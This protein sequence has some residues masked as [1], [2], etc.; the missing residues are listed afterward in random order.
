MPLL[1]KNANILTMDAHTPRADAAIIVGEYFAYMGDEN[2]ARAFLRSTGITDVDEYDCGGNFVMPGFNDSHMHFLNYVQGKAAVDLT[3]T[4]SVEDVVARMK[5]AIAQQNPKHGE[6]IVGRGWNQDY[7]TGEKRFPT[8]LDLDLASAE[9]PMVVLRVCGHVA[10]INSAAM[11]SSLIDAQSVKQYGSYADTWPNGAPNGMFKENALSAIKIK[12]RE[13]STE[14]ALQAILQS[15][16]D[17][18]KLGIT[19]IQ[20]NDF[21]I[22]ALDDNIDLL[23]ALRSAGEDGRLKVRMAQQITAENAALLEGALERG[24]NS[25]FASPRFNISAIKLFADGSLGARTAYLSAP[26]NDDSSTHGLT[27][28]TGNQLEQLVLNAHKHNMPA[29]IH[30]I[31]DAAVEMCLDAFENAKRRYPHLAPRHGI[32]HC[33]ITSKHQIE[34]I[35]K[36]DVLV[37]AQPIFL[38]YDNQIVIPRVGEALAAT[39][40]AFGDYARIGVH[41]SFGTDCPV[42]PFAPLP[43][44]YCA[45]SRKSLSGGEAYR[46]EQALSASEALHAYTVEGA[47]ATHEEH[48]KGSINEGKYADFIIMDA[49]LTQMP[50]EDIT[51]TRVLRTYV[52][53]ECVFDAENS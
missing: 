8:N 14:E 51:S 5:N 35:K 29:I 10:V 49:D 28:F 47:Y 42:E 26:Y 22:E 23:H 39:S 11:A 25:H 31:G 48:I 41:Q 4:A 16:K 15:Q 20:S 30:A 44:I 24:I 13:S 2:G 9:I 6:W 40:Y 18:L 34:R 7:F 1:L 33:Q 32:V 52:G 38:D 46:S 12:M 27:Y 21:D 17:L 45:I 3:G 37:Y 50:P 19:S 43:G 53:G 36:L